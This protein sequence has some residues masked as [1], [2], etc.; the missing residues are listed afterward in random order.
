MEYRYK[1]KVKYDGSRYYGFQR[2]TSR[3]TVQGEIERAISKV[4]SRKVEIVPASRTDRGVH[5][6]EQVFHYDVADKI[7]LE[8]LKFAINRVLED[9]VMLMNV[10][11]VDSSFHAR[12]N[13][14]E[15]TYRYDICIA[16]ERDVFSSRYALW[17]DKELDVTRLNQIGQ[18]FVGKKDFKAVMKSGSDKENTVRTVKKV[19]CYRKGDVV[20]IE[21]SSDGFL[22]NMVRI[23]VGAMLNVIEG[24]MDSLDMVEALNRGDRN[25]FKRTI[26]PVG[27]YLIKIDY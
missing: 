5:A 4:Y 26:S 14:L 8:K 10:E 9:D 1:C 13:V 15:K 3:K 25:F 22:Y 27:L 24:R 19:T 7:P 21:I 16:K 20:S 12:Y 17:Y 11:L 23:I 2:Q 6:L 18:L